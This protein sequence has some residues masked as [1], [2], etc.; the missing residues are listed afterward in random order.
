MALT[1]AE[2]AKY[3]LNHGVSRSDLSPEAQTEYDRLVPEGYGTPTEKRDQVPQELREGLRHTVS[4]SGNHIFRSALPG[5]IFAGVFIVSC[6][7]G[8]IALTIAGLLNGT[9]T[10]DPWAPGNFAALTALILG[11][12]ALIG[13]GVRVPFMRVRVHGQAVTITNRCRTYR[14][15]AAEI[16]RITLEQK[17]PGGGAV[18]R[19]VPRA[20]LADGRRI[21]LADL[22]CGRASED[23]D[24]KL[25]MILD[26]LKVLAGLS[27]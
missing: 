9:I 14:V 21:W 23:P 24:P 2:E 7:A 13:V 19:W 16:A 1:P 17:S 20:Y 11:V 27:T 4:R 18:D 12:L 10:G 3:A 15:N 8:V 26:E 25:V 22:H 5:R 6:G